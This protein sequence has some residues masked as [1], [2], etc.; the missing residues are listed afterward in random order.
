MSVLSK[1]SPFVTSPEH[2][3][4]LIKV[5]VP[6]LYAHQKNDAENNTLKTIRNL[7]PNV[8]APSAFLKPFSR[9]FS[10]LRSR[11]SRQCLCDVFT[12]LGELDGEIADV[13]SV[14]SRMNAWNAKRLDEP[15]YTLRLSG[16]SDASRLVTSGE[17]TGQRVLP[18]LQNCIHFVLHSE[19]LSVRDSAG[20]CLGN[21]V[22]EL[23]AREGEGEFQELVM[24]CVVP[25]CKRAL[26]SKNEVSGVFLS[27][28]TSAGSS[29][30]RL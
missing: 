10:H 7:L 18:A 5:L 25:A 23:A 3:A 12:T 14:V 16:F 29:F 19:D 1:L 11:S 27:V 30:R 2:S 4:T 15:D 21:I 22:Q 8:N 9:L 20:S 24:N 13:A 17:L 6:C 28:L 26:K